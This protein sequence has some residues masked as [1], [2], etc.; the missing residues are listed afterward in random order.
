M[1]NQ[2]ILWIFILATAIQLF[3]W[4]YFFARLAFYRPDSNR[5]QDS[6]FRIPHSAFE[7]VSVIICAHNEE[8]NLK[9]NINRFLNQTYRSYELLL[10][11]HKSSDKSLDVLSSLPGKFQNI[12][13]VN[14]ED[15]RVGKKFALATGIEQA[16]HQVLLLT[17]A[18]CV[19]ASDEWVSGMVAGMNENTQI[20]LGFAPY[21]EA[22]G[23]LNTFIRFEA[24][25]T[26]MQYF[27]FALAGIPYMGVGRNLAYR[28]E[29][30]ERTGGF[31]RHEHLAGG[32]DDLFINAAARKGKVGIRL[33]PQTFIFSEAKKNFGEYFRQKTRH[34]TT[35]R[36]YKLHHKLLLG[37]LAASHGL[38]Y[39]GVFLVAFKISIIFALL[40]YA[41]RMCVV[42]ALSS[43]ILSK[44]QHRSLRFWVPALDAALILYYI[45]FTPATLMNTTNTQRWN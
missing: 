4:L 37:I 5:E 28:R 34:Y 10:V 35:S 3:Y 15:A 40:G 25:Y 13:I 17:D 36:H 7:P 14:C 16:K 23:P 41:V 43:F 12:R 2:F 33:N 44:L 45:I 1:L 42:L 32:D 21:A 9:K 29:L 24:C 30:F 8:D 11:L 39:L 22:P 19:P 20:V 31:R 26:A 18:D 27:S 38:H 6:E